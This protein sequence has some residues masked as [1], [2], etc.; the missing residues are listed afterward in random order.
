MIPLKYVQ[1]QTQGACNANCVF[2]PWIESWHAKNYGVMDRALFS[3]ILDMLLP[4]KDNIEAGGKICPY[5][6]QE[7]FVD[8]RMLEL[9]E[10]I[11]E[12]FPGAILELS[13]NGALLTPDKVEKLIPMLEGKPHEIWVSHHGINKA[14]HEEIMK[15]NHER[16][17]GHLINLIKE[18]RGRLRIRVRGSGSSRNNTG[19]HWFT[20]Q[21][22]FDYWRRLANENNFDLGWIDLDYFTYHDRAGTIHRE[23]RGANQNNVGKVREIGPE[24]RF[25]CSRLQDWLHV[26]WNGDLRLCC[27]DYHGEVKLP[28]LNDMTISEYY[29]SRD[30]ANLKD[31][32]TGRV[33]SEDDF[34]CKRCTSPG[35]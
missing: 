4:W 31:K 26:M 17:T 18:A 35:G 6:M 8:K 34:I 22:Y 27:M 33:E 11:Q 15:I 14:T 13:T 25:A 3:R 16:S 24:N 9:C 28:N 20:R 32:V 30:F 23:E 1:I 21:E 5:L 2:C 7:P 12:K 10:E 29:L 19:R